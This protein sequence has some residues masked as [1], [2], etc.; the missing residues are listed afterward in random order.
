MG[1]RRTE[2]LRVGFDRVLKLEFHGAKVTSDAGLLAYR[3]LDEALDLTE[4]AGQHIEEWRTGKNTRHA[5]V[6]LLRQS[7]YSRLAGYEDTNDAERLCV[8][9]T[10][11]HIVGGRATEH[12]AAS[13]SQVGRFETEVLTQPSNLAALMD[14]SGQWVD[15][16]RQAKPIKNRCNCSPC[17][18]ASSLSLSTWSVRSAVRRC[19]CWPSP[20]KGL[21]TKLRC[22][23]S[24]RM[25]AFATTCG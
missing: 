8:D 1:E 6:G 10:M 18:M 12:S 13:T 15:R 21:P 25:C 9:P 23:A 24:A 14:L 17:P 3:E 2:A 4:V 7:I 5:T 19:R 11:R 16:V 22:A 20:Q